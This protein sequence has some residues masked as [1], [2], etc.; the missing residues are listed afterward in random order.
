MLLR[1]YLPV[2][3]KVISIAL[4]VLLAEISEAYLYACLATRDLATIGLLG[5]LAGALA[6]VGVASFLE[7]L[8]ARLSPFLRSAIFV[9]IVVFFISAG[10]T[11][12]QCYAEQITYDAR[13]LH[14]RAEYA[15]GLWGDDPWIMYPGLGNAGFGIGCQQLSSDLRES[16]VSTLKM[17]FV[18]LPVVLLICWFTTSK[19]SARRDPDLRDAVPV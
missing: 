3:G 8:W 14:P 13:M 1:D 2:M 19:L 4:F 15:S 6:G 12:Y 17:S 9:S 5:P 11:Y 7:L 10:T 18:W 16:I